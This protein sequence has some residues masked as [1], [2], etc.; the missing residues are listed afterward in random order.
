MTKSTHK[1]KVDKRQV[2]IVIIFILALYIILPQL[3]SFR[4]SWGHLK[5]LNIGWAIAAIALTL[6]TYFWAAL[7]YYFLSIKKLLYVEV[8]LVQFAAMFINRLLP[9]GVG[10]LGAN[11]AYLRH[12]NHSSAN[13]ST[14]VAVNNTLGIIGHSLIV[15]IALLFASPYSRHLI[16]LS[17]SKN[18]HVLLIIGVIIVLGVLCGVIFFR[19]RIRKFSKGVM[20]ELGSYAHH[21]DRL[22]GALGS[23]MLLTLANVLCLLCCMHALGVNLPFVVVLLIFTFGLSTGT[24]TPTPGGLGGYEAGL[25]GGFVAYH[26]DSSTA[27]AIALL[28]RF[29]SYWLALALGGVA[30]GF[31]QHKQLFSS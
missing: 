10:A 1:L 12:R 31:S 24:V 4:L 27:L 9:G 18:S 20:R 26:I 14:V 29:V 3:S 15:A 25:V 17:D 23:S 13:A 30:F 28:F 19:S 7:T 2:F 16:T 11:Y 6:S 8:I 5:H 22:V 21:L